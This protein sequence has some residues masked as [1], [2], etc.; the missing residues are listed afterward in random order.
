MS[1]ESRSVRPADLASPKRTIHDVAKRARV[2]ITTVSRTLNNPRSVDPSTAS[3]VWKAIEELNYYPNTQARSLVSGRSRIFGLIVS[4]ITNPFFPELVQGFEEVV[5]EQG[6]DIL[7]CSTN[8]DPQR[9]ALSVRRMLERKVDGVAIMTSEMEEHLIDQLAHRRVPIAF[10]DVGIPKDRV[11]NIAVDYEM[12]ICE[13][14]DHLVG[15]GHRRIGFV[16]G[17]QNLRS[18]RMRRAAF[19]RALERHG[20]TPDNRS[21][22]ESDHKVGGGLAAM[23]RILEAPY[24][25]T[26]MLA[27][28]DLTAVGMMRAARQAG[29]SVPHDLSIV[30]FDDIWLAEFTEPPLTTVRLSRRELAEK[31]C[32]ALLCGMAPPVES[33]RCAEYRVETHL[34][35]RDSTEAPGIH[36]Q[37]AVKAV[38]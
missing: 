38:I 24:R 25:P 9:M 34:I 2:S 33:Q 27:S 36:C 1:S 10:L 20:I 37:T 26:A 23:A 8:Y 30:G 12:G 3:R 11:S 19:F 4:D 31:A 13:A 35:V 21:V 22:I 14:I 15:L 7:L 16:S 29:L 17:P 28:N 5:N 32:Q 6:Y 18:A